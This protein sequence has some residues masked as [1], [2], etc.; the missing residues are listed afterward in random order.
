MSAVVNTVREDE[1]GAAITARPA[2]K[3]KVWTYV[4]SAAVLAAASAGGY[5]YY[6]QGQS[7]THKQQ[8]TGAAVESKHSDS[9]KA[10]AIYFSLQP[11]FVVNLEDTESMRYMQVDLDIMARNQSAIEDAKNNMPRI[12]N[13]LL[14]LFGQQHAFDLST[15]SGKEALQAKALVEIQRVLTEETGHPGIEA[16]YFS[17][18]VIQ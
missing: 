4:V 12:R 10:P 11:A 3:K 8:G 17:S 6:M 16:V 5:W 7:E 2:K 9:G 15:R 18:F 14:M 13:A 1:G